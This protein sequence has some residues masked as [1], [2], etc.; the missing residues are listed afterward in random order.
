MKQQAAL[1]A[2]LAEELQVCGHDDLSGIDLLDALAS[3]GMELI[4]PPDPA[5]RDAYR[6]SLRRGLDEPEPPR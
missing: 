5:T 4:Q 6:D 1:A 3:C 2:I